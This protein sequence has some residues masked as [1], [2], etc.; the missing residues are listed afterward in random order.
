MTFTKVSVSADLQ[1]KVESFTQE[2]FS[3]AIADLGSLVKIPGIA[4]PSFDPENLTRSSQAVRDLLL[5][6]ELFDFVDIKT[7]L[8]PNG[9]PGSPAVLARR[10]SKGGAPHVL[11]Y[12]HHDVQPPGNPELWESDPFQA[13]LKGERLFGRGVSDDKAGVIT[14]LYALKALKELAG[15]VDL[16][17]TLFIEGEEEAG[18][19]SFSNFLAD[20][21]EDLAADLIIVADSGNWSIDT[22]A[23]TSTLRGVVSQTFTLKTMDH[24]LHSGMFGGPLPD[25]MTAMIKLLATLIDDQGDVAIAGLKTVEV[26]ELPFSDADFREQAGL[27]DGVQR[28]GTHSLLKQ[29]WGA[30]SVTVIGIDAPAVATS[31]N[32]AQP[33]ITARISLRLAPGEDPTHG[34]KM[35][36]EHLLAK[37]PFGSHI[38]FGHSEQGPG[39]FAKQGWAAELAKEILGKVWPQPAVEI[40]V[41][42]SIP[43]IAEF[44]TVFPDAQILVTGVEDPDSRAHSPNE[45]QHLPTLKRAISAE[46]LLLLSGNQ[47]R[48]S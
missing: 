24:A 46:A 44:A 12:A 38:E 13:T 48:R 39:Y 19:E 18:S 32:T 15:N 36:K 4:W 31:S 1:A 5:E 43:F 37:A 33:E 3:Q 30:P 40:G 47:M 9:E 21:R 42:G 27:L 29:N 26:A 8:K 23:L 25:A 34:L 35:L 20:N 2:N 22:P 6:T 41:G 7:A 16:G 11:L 17:I 14:H 28:I 10:A 45:S